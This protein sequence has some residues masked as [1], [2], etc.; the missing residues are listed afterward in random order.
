LIHLS[1]SK[2]WKPENPVGAELAALASGVTG[3]LTGVGVAGDE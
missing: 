2:I 1:G 3:A